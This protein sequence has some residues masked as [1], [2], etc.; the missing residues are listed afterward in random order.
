MTPFGQEVSR[1][2]PQT[3]VETPGHGAVQLERGPEPS[4]VSR[5]SILNIGS[6]LPADGNGRQPEVSYTAVDGG[7]MATQKIV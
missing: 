2:S 6:R 5:P 7:Q 1:E 3:T 4:Q